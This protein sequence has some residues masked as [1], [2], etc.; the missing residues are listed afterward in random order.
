MTIKRAVSK[1]ETLTAAATFNNDDFEQR[2]SQFDGKLHKFVYQFLHNLP[3]PNKQISGIIFCSSLAVCVYLV[4][5]ATG[6]FVNL[7]GFYLIPLLLGAF[8]FDRGYVYINTVF[9]AIVA[10]M[11]FRDSVFP[12]Q[13]FHFLLTFMPFLLGFGLTSQFV[14]M[15]KTLIRSL[16]E[17]V[18]DLED[19]LEEM[20]DKLHRM[21]NKETET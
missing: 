11:S 20:K 19:D 15:L 18:E 13:S 3:G 4:D 8:Y 5:V 12:N 17:H 2:F 14:L 7:R 16:L 21:S 9:I 10:T 1:V 6:P